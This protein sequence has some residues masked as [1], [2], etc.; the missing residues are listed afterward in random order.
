MT[1]ECFR[2]LWSQV[3]VTYARRVPAVRFETVIGDRQRFVMHSRWISSVRRRATFPTIHKVSYSRSYK[4]MPPPSTAPSTSDST[5]KVRET[6][7]VMSS[8]LSKA[9]EAVSHDF[10]SDTVTGLHQGDPRLIVVPTMEMLQSMFTTA[11]FADDLYSR[12]PTTV[13]LE[14]K[15]AALAGHES[16]MFV[17][18]GTMGNQL[19]LRTHLTQPP[20][21]V[22]CDYRAHIYTNEAGALAMLS[23]AMTTTVQ[24]KNGKYITLEEVK[25]NIVEEDDHYAPT[26]LVSLEN[27]IHGV[28]LPY[29]EAKRISEYIRSEYKG[30]IKLHLDGIPLHKNPI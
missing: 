3:Q 8:N 1:L 4:V 19:C 2:E 10:R 21:S 22:L 9:L 23:Q 26:R 20:H 7:E 30:K 18:S 13:E 28:V 11:T 27:T 12:D 24:P 15:V 17:P 14:S 6:A 25:A 5:A 29:S 16:A